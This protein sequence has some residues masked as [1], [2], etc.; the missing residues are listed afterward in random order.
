MVAPAAAGRRQS[1]P[2]AA[3]R[4]DAAD[5]RLADRATPT[6]SSSCSRKGA[7]VNARATRGQTALM[8]AVAQKH[9]D[10]VKLL[11]AHGADVHARS[12][13]WSQVMAVL[14]ARHARVQPDDSARRRHRADVRGPGRRSRVGEA[15]RR[16]RRQRQRRRR[17]GRE[18]HGAGGACRIPAISCEFLLDKGADANTSGDGFT[19]LHAAIMRRDERMVGALLAHG[20][21]PNAP[22]TQLDADAPFVEGLELQSRSGR[23]DPALA[24][25]P[26][27][28]PRDHAPAG[29]AGREPARRAP[30]RVSRGRSGRDAHADDH[31][32]DGGGRHG[33][34]GAAVGA[35]RSRGARSADA[36]SRHAGGRAWASTSMP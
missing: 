35:N 20:A 6:W 1:E 24:R 8:W 2:R 19:A 22:V 33:W 15:A 27:H 17:L 23:R 5:G 30:C 32:A 31:A 9:P 28:A 36:R 4:R 14:A 18:R 10:V 21:D 29:E 26:R 12:K 7:S 16:R 3:R 11:L 34:P 13:V 25:G